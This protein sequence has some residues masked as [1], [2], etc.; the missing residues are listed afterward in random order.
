MIQNV[1]NNGEVE[2]WKTVP[3]PLGEVLRKD[4]GNNFKRV[5]RALFNNEEITLGHKKINEQGIYLE[6]GAPEMFGVRMIRGSLNGLD[7]LPGTDLPLAKH[8]EG[9]FWRCR[10]DESDLRD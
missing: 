3:F 2:T 1:T 10:P 4:Y 8:G 7:N 9:I 6:P 5:V